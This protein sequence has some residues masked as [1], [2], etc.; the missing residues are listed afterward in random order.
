MYS[1]SQLRRGISTPALFGRELNRL[2]HRRLYTREYNTD[3]IDIVAADWDNMLLLDACRY[4]L[5]EAS[6]SVEGNLSPRVSRGSN[7]REFLIGNFHSR[8]LHDMVYVTA[9][10]MLY[11]NRDSVDVEFHAEVDIWQGDGWNET[12]QTVL[13]EETAD[14]ALEA[15]ET[16]P[17]KR[18]LIHF[19]QPHYPFIASA[20][21][22]FEDER[23]FDASKTNCWEQ[24][25]RGELQVSTGAIWRAYEANLERALESVERLLESLGG[26]SVVTS[27]HGNMIGERATP[28]PVRE[29][30][31]PYGIYT[32]E[33]VQVPWLEVPAD[34]RRDIVAEEPRRTGESVDED[35]VVSR[36]QELGYAEP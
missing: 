23:A 17:N 30:G 26:K 15:A 1:L 29:W 8:E 20:D 25:L 32:P 27:D 19:I 14:H 3:G 21:Q 4:D 34:N 35:T 13:P 6:S 28:V 16:Y 12:H 11:R 18:L 5:F 7:T 33:L 10:P 2:Y 36:L 24:V 31:H 9:S 22:P